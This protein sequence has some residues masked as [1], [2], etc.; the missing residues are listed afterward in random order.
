MSKATDDNGVEKAK[1]VTWRLVVALLSFVA[2]LIVFIFLSHLISSETENGF[3]KAA[4]HVAEE[5]TSSGLTAFFKAITFFGSTKFL[6]SAYCIIVLY[7]LVLKR[8]TAH[9]FNIAAIGLTSAALLF[10]FKRIFKRPRPLHPLT[11]NFYGFSYPSGHSFSA[12]TF[13]GVLVYILWQSDV[14]AKWKWICSILLFLFAS[15]VAISRVYLHVHYASD[16]A[17]GF[18]LSALWLG[19]SIFIL[20]K[21]VRRRPRGREQ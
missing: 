19:L 7:F 10:I 8:S 15:L 4:F 2:I 16:V 18:C 11:N 17:A 6:F 21:V 13:A 1:G 9:S 12:F 14:S 20:E 5:H 3:D